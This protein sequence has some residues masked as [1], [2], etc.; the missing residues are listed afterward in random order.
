MPVDERQARAELRAKTKSKIEKVFSQLA[1]NPKAKSILAELVTDTP[2]P[3][4]GGYLQRERDIESL[5]AASS[6]H[7]KLISA[8]VQTMAIVEDWFFC[9]KILEN[10]HASQDAEEFV[11]QSA[12]SATHLGGQ[13][14]DYFKLLSVLVGR[15]GDVRLWFETILRNEGRQTIFAENM[16]LV[17]TGQV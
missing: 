6:G 10:E 7:L 14:G 17:L 3:G 15:R 9:H 5:I 12:M 1:G 4:R 16:E 13:S 11:A 8:I 2:M